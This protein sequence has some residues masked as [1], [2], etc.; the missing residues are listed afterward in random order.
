MHQRLFFATRSPNRPNPIGLSCVKL[1]GIEKTKEHGT[2]LYV[3][4]ADLMDG[5]PIFDI[6]PYL[7]LSDVHTDAVCGFAEKIEEYVLDVFIP[8]IH[9]NKL[10]PEHLE[11]VTKILSEDP[12]PSYQNDPDREYGMRFAD[13]EIF[14]KVADK[15]LTVTRVEMV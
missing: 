6:K 13:Y 11:T 10:A 8:D 12:R 1:E 15:E 5:T 4:G 7:T 3:S 14:F 2:V 9:K